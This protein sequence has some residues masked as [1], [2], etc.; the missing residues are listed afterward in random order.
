MKFALNW[1][2]DSNDRW[3]N[4]LSLGSPQNIENKV[5]YRGETPDRDLFLKVH[6]KMILLWIEKYFN[7]EDYLKDAEGRPII[8]MYFP[9]TRKQEQPIIKSL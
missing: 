3:M 8:Y 1:L 4:W 2:D 9:T 7:R 6:D 5:N